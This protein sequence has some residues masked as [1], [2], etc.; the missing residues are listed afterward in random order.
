MRCSQLN[1]AAGGQERRHGKAERQGGSHHGFFRGTLTHDGIAS[2]GIGR[3]GPVESAR[4]A[5]S[6]TSV[7]I[8][9]AWPL[10][11]VFCDSPAGTACGE[12]PAEA[13]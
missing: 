13:V 12:E 7:G 5:H 10:N 9:H 6:D 8:E 2:G 3:R 4:R 11:P 1:D